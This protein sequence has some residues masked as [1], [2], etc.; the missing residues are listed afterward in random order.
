MSSEQSI[1]ETDK[2]IAD[3]YHM[4]L[5]EKN[6]LIR[7]KDLR[8]AEKDELNKA[9]MLLVE[10]ECRHREISKKVAHMQ[11]LICLYKKI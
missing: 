2:R 1:N 9:R 5:E 11:A 10:Y 4:L 7:E 8:L 3:L 6:L